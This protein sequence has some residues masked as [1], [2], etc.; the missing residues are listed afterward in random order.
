[1]KSIPD[2]LIDNAIPWIFVPLAHEDT[3]RIHLWIKRWYAEEEADKA[4][5]ADCEKAIRT[6][7]DS[8]ALK[9]NTS[10]FGEVKMNSLRIYLGTDGIAMPETCFLDIAPNIKRIHSP[11]RPLQSND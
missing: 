5:A 7:F 3:L 9:Y 2:E 1:M 11:L 10:K 4:L 8:L 6:A